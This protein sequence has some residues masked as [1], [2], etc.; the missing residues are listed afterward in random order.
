MNKGTLIN[1]GGRERRLRFDVNSIC[2]FE[3]VSGVTAQQLMYR[4]GVAVSRALLWAG[5]KAEEPGLTLAQVGDWMQ[6]Y[7]DDHGG[8]LSAGEAMSKAIGD[9]LIMAGI[10]AAP[11]QNG[12]GQDSSGERPAKAE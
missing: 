11:S 2:D 9:A 7:A 6:Q 1:L 3:Q 4:S 10:L 5:L 8:D 12:T